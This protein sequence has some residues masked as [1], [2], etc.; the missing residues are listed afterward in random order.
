MPRKLTGITTCSSQFWVF[1]SRMPKSL[2]SAQKRRKSSIGGVQGEGV[3]EMRVDVDTLS[4]SVISENL[5]S[6]RNS[7]K[8]TR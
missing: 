3:L 1:G 8:P 4:A 2:I 5:G 6:A 7:W